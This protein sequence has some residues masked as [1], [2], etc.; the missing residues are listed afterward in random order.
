MNNKL[1]K[2]IVVINVISVCVVFLFAIAFTFGSGYTRIADERWARLNGLLAYD[3]WEN[4][5]ADEYN[6][7]AV[8]EYDVSSSQITRKSISSEFNLPPEQLTEIVSDV[9]AQAKDAGTISNRVQ[10]CKK[11]VEGTTRVVLFDRFSS[12]SNL[13]KYTW[14]T[15]TVLLLGVLSYFAISLILAH[16]ALKPVEINW[17]KQKQFVAD[18]SHELKTP[19]SVIMANTEIIASHADETVESQRKWIENTRSESQRMA[20]LVNDL[21][22]LAKND[23]GHK[24]QMEVVN[25]S[26]SIETV[27]L[28]QESL[29]YENGKAFSYEITPDLRVVGNVGQLKQL[30]TIL[31]D[32]ANKY[33]TGEGNIS[34]HVSAVGKHAQ[35]S[36]SN[37]CAPLTEE[38]LDHL[39]DRFYTVD[40]SRNK[41][42]TGN[43]LGLSIAQVICKTHRG[44]I[45]VDYADGV[46][47]FTAI[48]PLKKQPSSTH[49]PVNEN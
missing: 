28:S 39:F 2:K 48:L 31:L 34:L 30:A 13:R 37:A 11:T 46:V 47:T 21:L 20:E 10:Y 12:A 16:I 17:A 44:S 38:Q 6:G 40:Q 49:S 43:G 3:N 9:L 41:N 19:L 7:A 35:L 4:D 25:L 23:D 5:L 29:F 26:E 27:V 24:A 18:A 8:I 36:V 15:L 1:R 42:V 45:R 14:Y 32:N 22:F 33:S